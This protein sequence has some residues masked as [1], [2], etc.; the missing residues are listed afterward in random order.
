[1]TGVKIIKG[2]TG[3]GMYSNNSVDI[4]NKKRI[5]R[6]YRRYKAHSRIQTVGLKTGGD[7]FKEPDRGDLYEDVRGEV[8]MPVLDWEP[9][10]RR[11]RGRPRLTWMECVEDEMASL[12]KT[13][14][15]PVIAHAYLTWIGARKAQYQKLQVIG[16]KVL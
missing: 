12:Y 16:D 10:G 9:T 4:D 2:E 11:E 13:A 6:S 1:M 7:Y 14:L 8:I 15:R 3:S 5:Y